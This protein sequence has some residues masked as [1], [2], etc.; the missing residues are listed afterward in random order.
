[1]PLTM[2]EQPP[3]PKAPAEEHPLKRARKKLSLVRSAARDAFFDH[4][5][6]PDAPAPWDALM[7]PET[8]KYDR[9]KALFGIVRDA[10]PDAAFKRLTF[11][12]YE[13][14]PDELAVNP[15]QYEF[16]A[17]KLD[18]G[19]EC[20]V[21]R[22]ISKRPDRPNLVIK[23]DRTTRQNVDVLVERGKTIRA[24]YEEKQEW[25]RDLPGLIPEEMQF[26]GKSPRGGRIALFTIQEY[27]G[28]ASE[29]HDLF[30]DYTPADLAQLA[31]EHPDLRH[32]LLTFA[33]I[34]LERAVARDEMVDTLGRKNVAIVD[35]T[36][37]PRLMLL[38]AHV[39]HHPAHPTY[40]GQDERIAEH[41]DFL[42]EL[43]A[44]LEAQP[45]TS[46]PIPETVIAK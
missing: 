3:K 27:L 13:Y 8:G 14:R 41:L 34:T 28:S 15:E 18:G 16:E 33:R 46:A 17:R 19:G 24:E 42:R 10:V 26:I 22:L 43:V 38:D 29:I 32:A 11:G 36:E 25:Y 31:S 44:K 45:D 7:D 1:M 12:H 5:D 39:V 21:Y 30:H 40:P 23:I 35:R 4:V 20:S 2:F 6:S 9:V 37:G